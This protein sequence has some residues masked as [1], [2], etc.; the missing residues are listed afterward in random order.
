MS[1]RARYFRR[2]RPP[3]PP[4][5]IALASFLIC[6]RQ[7]IDRMPRTKCALAAASFS[8][9]YFGLSLSSGNIF[10]RLQSVLAA[11][12]NAAVE[13]RLRRLA[14]RS[15]AA[16]RQLA[17]RS[18]DFSKKSLSILIVCSCRKTRLLNAIAKKEGSAALK[19]RSIVT[20]M[21]IRAS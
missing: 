12:K 5:R 14:I 17:N 18:T 16:H 13:R 1:A 9:F 8:R 6:V 7:Q 2:R 4:P 20:T 11:L 10:C 3:P 21:Q 19:I 15:L